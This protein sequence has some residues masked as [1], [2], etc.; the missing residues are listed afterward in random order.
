MVMPFH[1]MQAGAIL[2]AKFA[3]PF[4]YAAPPGYGEILVEQ[5]LL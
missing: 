3:E 1:A 2:D 5:N 4:S